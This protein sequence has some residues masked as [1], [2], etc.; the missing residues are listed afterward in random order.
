MGRGMPEGGG[1]GGRLVSGAPVGC[2]IVV[3]KLLAP[4][5]WSCDVSQRREGGRDGG[6]EGRREVRERGTEDGGRK[7]QREGA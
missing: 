2:Q 1:G 4:Y 3:S 7:G 5:S 6:R